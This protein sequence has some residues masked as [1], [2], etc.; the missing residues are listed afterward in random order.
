MRRHLVFLLVLIGFAAPVN[1]QQYGM[2]AYFARLPELS[3]EQLRTDAASKDKLKRSFAALE[4]HMRSGN[5]PDAARAL[6]YFNEALKADSTNAWAHFGLGLG[7]ARVK[8][9]TAAFRVLNVSPA[10]AVGIMEH[11]LKIALR[12]DPDLSEAL[13]V[14]AEAT[15]KLSQTKDAVPEHLVFD[16]VSTGEES[17]LEK[18]RGAATLFR[19][20]RDDEG[21][22]LYFAG[23]ERADSAALQAYINDMQLLATAQEMISVTDGALTKRVEAV[24]RFWR[25]RAVRDGITQAQRLGVHYRRMNVALSRYR[26]P[27]QVLQTDRMADGRKRQGMERALD[28]RGLIYIRYG[29]PNEHLGEPGRTTAN[30]VDFEAWAYHDADGKTRIYFFSNGVFEADPNR[31]ISGD[32][33]FASFVYANDARAAFISARMETIRLN[34]FAG[35]PQNNESLQEDMVRLNRRIKERTIEKIFAALQ[36]DLATPRYRK[37]LIVFSDFA[38]FRGKGCTDLVYTVLAPVPSFRLNIAVADTFTWNTQALDTTVAARETIGGANLRATGVL[39][40]EPDPNAYVSFSVATD[41]SGA[42]S[43]G[44]L[45][46]PDYRGSGL[47]MSDMLFAST[48]P[49]GFVRGTAHLSLI[50]PRQFREGEAFRVFYELYNLPRGRRYK[51]DITLKTVEPNILLRLFKGGSSNTVSFDDVSNADGVLQ[52]LRTLIPQVHPGEVLI[53]IKVTDLQ[54]GETATSSEKIWVIPSI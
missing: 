3:L 8:S 50:P 16:V 7:L 13:S 34:N 36:S 32:E 27:M 35:M 25:K 10:Q 44:D 28:D 26:P 31:R 30:P 9:K 23:L 20:G 11:E 19:N 49:G 53:T 12:I 39:C 43:G 46:I 33:R 47:L 54:T 41:S 52:E 38:T 24:R 6:R 29:E 21:G 51:T 17:S 37:P 2:R 40:T 42:T 1:A 45:R 4:L 22:K 18:L 5:E 48:Q 15:E 14:L